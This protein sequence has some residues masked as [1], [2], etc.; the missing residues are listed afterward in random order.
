MVHRRV[1][2]QFGRLDETRPVLQKGDRLRVEGK[3]GYVRYVSEYF[4]CQRKGKGNPNPKFIRE[5]FD[6]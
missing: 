4:T 1:I 3:K 2:R 6:I 5:R